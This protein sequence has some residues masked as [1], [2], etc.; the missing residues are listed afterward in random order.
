MGRLIVVSNRVGDVSRP[1]Q[2]GGLAVAVAD[3][4]RESGG[5]W[6]GWNGETIAKDASGDPDIG[7]HD[8]VTTIAIP[9]KKSDFEGY[10]D[11]YANSVLWPLFHYRLD[12]VNYRP[13]FFKAYL[14]VNDALAKALK[15]HLQD[16]DVIW[17]HDYHLIPFAGS[18]RR[19]GCRQRLGFFLHIPFPPPE[20][21]TASPNHA[22]LAEALLEFDV[23]GF[24]SSTDLANFRRYVEE[25]GYGT[26]D[27][28]TLKVGD[29]RIL[30][31]RFPIGI[32]V[33][34]FGELAQTAGDEVRIDKMRRDIIGRKQIIGVDRLDY[35]KGIPDRFQAMDRLLEHHP[36]LERKVTLL[37]IAPPTRQGIG[38]Y[39]TIRKETEGLAGSINGKFADFDWTPIRYIH[40]T[41]PR[42]KLAALF[43]ASEVGLV[44]PLR[45]GMNLVAKEYVA[46]QDPANPG[47]LVLSQF[48][49]AAEEMDEALIVNPH[50]IDEMAVSLF[51][52]LAM[53]LEERRERHEALNGRIRRYDVHH[54]ARDFL[55]L[56]RETPAKGDGQPS[57]EER[58]SAA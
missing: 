51:T 16:D 37:Q 2:T 25:N 27:G 56:L 46:A 15:P 26:T 12:L 18:L 52:A 54:W 4:L 36:E 39:A 34:A 57:C 24:Q 48:A 10:Y 41:V 49:G 20:M 14:K 40:R 50:D 32:D 6:F 9:L 5:I 8:G 44:T 7:T 30:A 23:I 11:G 47:V 45:D 28:E 53:P 58:R 13:A 17:A 31:G 3:A 42:D 33:D 1:T 29:R 35:S 55:R 21:L 43:R 19:L 22:L 38:A